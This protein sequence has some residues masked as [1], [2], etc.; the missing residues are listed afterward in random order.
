MTKRK[1]KIMLFHLIFW[2]SLNFTVFIAFVLSSIYAY[3]HFSDGYELITDI[4][5]YKYLGGRNCQDLTLHCGEGY[6]KQERG[7]PLFIE[8]Y[9]WNKAK[10][11]Y[12][13]IGPNYKE[14]TIQETIFLSLTYDLEVYQSALEDVQS[15][16]GYSKVIEFQYKSYIFNLNYSWYNSIPTEDKGN[17]YEFNCEKP[18]IEEILFVCHSDTLCSI[19]FL[20]FYQLQHE[21]FYSLN[22]KKVGGYPFKGWDIFLNDFYSFYDWEGN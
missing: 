10:Y 14:N 6:H 1:K 15:Q 4:S 8:T 2:P 5:N 21:N 13:Y 9:N 7:T 16:M 19:V 18:Y 12:E 20:S 3:F 22:R 17:Y 11:R